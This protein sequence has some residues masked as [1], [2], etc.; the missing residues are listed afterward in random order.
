MKNIIRDFTFSP[1]LLTVMGTVSIVSY[2]VLQSFLL[3][4]PIKVAADNDD[5]PGDRLGGGTQWVAPSSSTI[6]YTSYI[7]E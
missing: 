7:T 5:F 4:S 3:S 2:I 1:Q 6:E